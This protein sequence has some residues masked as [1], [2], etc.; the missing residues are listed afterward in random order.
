MKTKIIDPKTGVT[1]R[2]IQDA[3]D[4]ER[5]LLKMQEDGGDPLVLQFGDGGKMLHIIPC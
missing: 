2:L 5:C 4:L 1:V 3:E